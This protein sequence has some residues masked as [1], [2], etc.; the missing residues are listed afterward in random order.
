ME[1]FVKMSSESSLTLEG[2]MVHLG[3]NNEIMK[4]ILL[5]QDAKLER[6]ENLL[7][8]SKRKMEELGA[9]NVIP[10]QEDVQSDQ[11]DKFVNELKNCVNTSTPKSKVKR[12]AEGDESEDNVAN[13]YGKICE[14][15]W[16]CVI[17]ISQN[18][19]QKFSASI[20]KLLSF[21][22]PES[23]HVMSR[24]LLANRIRCVFSP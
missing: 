20:A 6:I 18:F 7:L 15:S 14:S 17:L 5:N 1:N 24:K 3:T 4:R 9:V 23:S 13:N 16:N 2:F 22:V 11:E 10:K 19:L 12:A 21:V 8:E